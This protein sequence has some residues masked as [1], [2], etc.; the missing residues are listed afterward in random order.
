MQKTAKLSFRTGPQLPT[1]NRG[2]VVARCF[3]VD[4]TMLNLFLMRVIAMTGATYNLI[5]TMTFRRRDVRQII[6]ATLV[7]E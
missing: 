6:N 2:A 1:Q 3:D 4:A 7:A 5:N